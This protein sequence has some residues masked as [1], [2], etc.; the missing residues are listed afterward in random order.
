MKFK[1]LIFPRGPCPALKAENIQ[2]HPTQ[3]ENYSN[4][5]E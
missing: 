4:I 1:T 2:D 3:R 5:S